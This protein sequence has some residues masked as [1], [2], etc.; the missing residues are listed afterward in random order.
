MNISFKY[1][2]SIPDRRGN[3]RLYFWRGKGH[4]RI[5]LRE[6]VGSAAFVERYDKL[7][8]GQR[9]THRARRVKTRTWQWLCSQYMASPEFER[10]EPTTQ[11]LR[12]RILQ[13][14]YAEPVAP[15]A[16]EV[17]GDFPIDRLGSRAIRVLRD[18]KA[19]HPHAANNRLKA[20]R[21]VFA[22][23]MEA[24]H[25]GDNPARDVALLRARSDGHHSWSVAEVEQFE[26]RHPI[27]TK[28]RL[29]LDL[30]LYTGSRR[31]DVVRL[32]RQHVRNGWLRFTQ[33]KTRVVVELPILPALQESIDMTPTGELTFLVSEQGRAFS[34]AG[35]GNWFR[36]RC[37]EARL[38][39]CSAHGLR[40]AS[41]A[42]AAE[43]GATASQLM[44]LFGWLNLREA[45]RYTKA[46]QRKKLA[47]AAL[48]LLKRPETKAG[49]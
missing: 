23:T 43:N 30:L 1:V 16:A 35:F 2:Y 14:T 40:K 21:Y 37:D 45:E 39:Q 8:R 13:S 47:S 46:A 26:T 33:H 48:M 29:A 12:R 15:G 9:S 44:A 19:H 10:L 20:I 6:P 34:A 41:A 18:R 17:F 28:A 4:P 25:I 22:W 5:R 3:E 31:S 42:G 32:G 38:R 49:T 27:G 24:E 7:L 36:D 11:S